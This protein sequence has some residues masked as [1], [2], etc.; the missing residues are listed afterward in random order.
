MSQ[1]TLAVLSA[2]LI[3]VALITYTVLAGAD[4]GGGIWDLFARGPRTQRE[5]NAIAQAMGPVWESNHVW[6]IYVIVLTW[7]AFPLV[8]AGVSTAL[9]IPIS[10]ALVGII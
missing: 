4:F 5:R 7:T 2:C 8:Y 9:F 10:L 3:L 6:L 1:H